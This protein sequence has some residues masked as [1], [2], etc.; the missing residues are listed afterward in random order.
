MPLLNEPLVHPNGVII[1]VEG[2][3]KCLLLLTP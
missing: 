1:N 3:G 2:F